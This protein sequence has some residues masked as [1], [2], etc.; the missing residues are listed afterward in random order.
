MKTRTKIALLVA[1][2]SSMT[3]QL[4]IGRFNSIETLL[5]GALGLTLA[6]T[7]VP[8]IIGILIYAVIKKFP[9]DTFTVLT[10][11][12]TAVLSNILLKYG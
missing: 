11:I 9:Q 5:G 2:L 7:I 12:M 8:F 6:I 3:V 1:F 10:Y 4:Y